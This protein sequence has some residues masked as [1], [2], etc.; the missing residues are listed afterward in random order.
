MKLSLK[1]A[2]ALGVIAG[3]PAG[4]TA[5]ALEKHGHGPEEVDELMRLGYVVGRL[6]RYAHPKIEVPRFWVTTVG[7]SVARRQVQ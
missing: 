3:C 4:V 5:Y 6:D 7:A 1:E 2:D